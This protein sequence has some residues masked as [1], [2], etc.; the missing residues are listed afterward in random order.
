MQQVERISLADKERLFES[1][2]EEI[3]SLSSLKANDY[4]NVPWQ[5][6]GVKG[7]FCDM[8]KKYWR[9]KTLL[10]DGVKPKLSEGIEDSLIDMAIYSILALIQVRWDKELSLAQKK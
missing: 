3:K 9:L 10:W 1:I 2:L 6:L 5:V 4:G 7:S 8:S